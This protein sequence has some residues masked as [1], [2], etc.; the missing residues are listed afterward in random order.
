MSVI[1]HGSY[2]DIIVTLNL[3]AALPDTERYG[4]SARIG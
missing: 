2:P 3:V 4:V 1:G